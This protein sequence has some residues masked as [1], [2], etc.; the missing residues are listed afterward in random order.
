MSRI[1]RATAS[2]APLAV[3]VVALLLLVSGLLKA[4]DPSAF[5]EVLAGHGLLP[6]SWL[7]PTTTGVWLTELAAGLIGVRLAILQPPKGA[8][9]GALLLGAVFLGF[10]MYATIL[11]VHPPPKPSPCGC[12]L[13]AEPVSNWGSVAMRNGLG[14]MALGS[15]ALFTRHAQPR[16]LAE[17]MPPPPPP[18]TPPT[19]SRTP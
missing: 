2:V 15:L 10:A 18:N 1:C 9:I 13:G 6:A 8:A 7:S 19:S 12:F 14:A 5:R 16:S 11:T 3:L 4:A 17:I